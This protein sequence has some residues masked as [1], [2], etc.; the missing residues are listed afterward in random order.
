MSFCSSCIIHRKCWILCC[1]QHRSGCT[2]M[3]CGHQGGDFFS[4]G[5]GDTVCRL[6]GNCT[7][8]MWEM[9]WCQEHKSILWEKG[10]SVCL[11]SLGGSLGWRLLEK[12]E[13]ITQNVP[14]EKATADSTCLGHRFTGQLKSCTFL[15]CCQYLTP[16]FEPEVNS[17]SSSLLRTLEHNLWNIKMV[18][19]LFLQYWYP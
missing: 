18:F 19:T 6:W 16:K 4:A 11:S 17:H 5:L 12:V 2:Q 10:K 9:V 8:S 14:S 15:S 1:H 3:T 13:H 7:Y